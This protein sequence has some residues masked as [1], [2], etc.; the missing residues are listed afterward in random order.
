MI[1]Q[2]F[3]IW[4]AT[5]TRKCSPVEVL[6]GRAKCGLEWSNLDCNICYVAS[7]FAWYR[8][9]ISDFNNYFIP[10]GNFFYAPF[11]VL[12]CSHLL[13]VS[14]FSCPWS[15]LL[16][17]CSYIPASSLNICFLHW[18]NGVAMLLDLWFMLVII[19]C[20]RIADEETASNFLLKVSVWWGNW[21]C[22]MRQSSFRDLL[23]YSETSPRT[24]LFISIR[25]PARVAYRCLNKHSQTSCFR[26]CLSVITSVTNKQQSKVITILHC[27]NLYM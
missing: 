2:H 20:H 8:Y 17:C 3:F 27:V 14:S 6:L 22:T 21:C 18:C 23:K 7:S 26:H 24:P 19:W 10:V 16:I 12:F 9:N 15:L 25:T 4:F 5:Q 11:A 1:N 13:L